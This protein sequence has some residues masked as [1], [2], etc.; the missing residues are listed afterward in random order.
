MLFSKLFT[1]QETFLF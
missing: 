1:S